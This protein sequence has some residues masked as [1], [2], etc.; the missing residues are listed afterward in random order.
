MAGRGEDRR[1]E[2]R[3]RGIVVKDMRREGTGERKE[4]WTAGC[5]GSGDINYT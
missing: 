1:G 5:S 4:R 2:E 3:T